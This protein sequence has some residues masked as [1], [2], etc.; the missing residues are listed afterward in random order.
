MI[1]A[2]LRAFHGVATHGSFTHAA[3]MLH[4]TQPTLSGQVKALEERYGVKLFERR[5]HGIELTEFGE[6][7][8]A[9]TR[10]LFR[11][12]DEVEQLFLSAREL[13]T[14]N[15]RVGADSPYFITPLL[16]QF[17]RRYPG[18]HL[19]IITGNSRELMRALETHRCEIAVLP[20]VP[21]D[22][23]RLHAIALAPDKL[24]VF[25]NKSH[26]WAD[27]RSIRIEELAGERIVLREQGS[28]TRAIFETAM[29]KANVPLNNTLEISGR[30]G[31]REAVAAG[32]GIGVVSEN[33]F[34]NDNRLH[35]LTVKNARL[36][37]DEYVVCLEKTKPMRIVSAFLEILDTSLG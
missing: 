16:A 11:H 27:R 17:H 22:D 30:E 14:G 15:L 12:E 34:G 1:H 35:A 25:T 21:V 37:H 24:V 13:I 20:N 29:Q 19:S 3:Q 5:G 4:V 26:A 10:Q 7:A 18:I 33:E 31:V 36:V 2:H 6:A 9:I 8:L 28:T 23:E 32:L